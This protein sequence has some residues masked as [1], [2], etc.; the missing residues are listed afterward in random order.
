MGDNFDDVMMRRIMMR[1]NLI[2]R[3]VSELDLENII[4]VYMDLVEEVFVYREESKELGGIGG[5]REKINEL[6]NMKGE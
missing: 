6:E 1:D 3:L 2:E 4:N 5:L